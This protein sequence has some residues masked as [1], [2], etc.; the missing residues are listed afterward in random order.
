MSKLVVH[1]LT[2]KQLDIFIDNPAQAVM[3]VGP[4][5]SGK[6]SLATQMAELVLGLKGK[7]FKTYGY[8]LTI[9]PIEGKA[10]GIESIR[11]LEHFLS[12]KVPSPT[13]VNRIVIIEDG[14]LLTVEAQNALLKTL[15]EP[16]QGTVV[17][18]TV[19]HEQSLLPTIRS[20]TQPII[21]H[22]PA[23]DITEKYFASS[24]L[25]ISQ[26]KRSYDISGGLPG[27][28][29]AI[30]DE[31]DHQLL[32]ATEQARQL[33]SRPVYERLL[34]VDELS[35]QRSLVASTIYI[36]QQMAH[37]SLQTATGHAATRWQAVLEA[38]YK[39]SDALQNNAQPKLV[40]TNLV[41]QF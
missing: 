24:G 25:D 31:S 29:Q 11:Q 19:N 7:D 2:K 15:E 18:M 30:L 10:I 36:L 22:K 5:G 34:L 28:M 27:L 40:L 8:G 26:V 16:P 33:L 13:K 39:A 20:R 4:T 14:H 12:L 35:K 23:R 17:I 32:A 9:S 1:P 38:S 37:V 21:V 3:L 6:L 41:L